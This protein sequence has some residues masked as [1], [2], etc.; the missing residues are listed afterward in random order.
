MFVDRI[1][2]SISLTAELQKKGFSIQAVQP[3]APGAK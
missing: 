2:D 1:T 3:I